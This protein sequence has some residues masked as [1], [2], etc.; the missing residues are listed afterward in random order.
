M[1]LKSCSDRNNFHLWMLNG[2]HATLDSFGV[3]DACELPDSYRDLISSFSY[4]IELEDFILVHAGLNFGIPDPLTDREAMLW[5][6]DRHVVKEL[7]GGKR[8]IGGHTPLNRDGIQRSLA[9][10][11]IMLDNG[12]VYKD[13]PGLGSLTALELQTMTLFFQENIDM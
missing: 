3:E 2:G 12:C 11:H 6:R 13:E 5:N 8:L 10:D 9:E 1:L 4:F 7:I